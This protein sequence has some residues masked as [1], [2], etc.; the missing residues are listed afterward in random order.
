MDNQTFSFETDVL[1]IGGGFSGSWAAM[2]ARSHAEN[3]LIVDKGPRDWGGLGSMSGGDMIVKGAE[4]EALD[5]VD[6][7]VYYYDGLCE[8][9]I[10]FDILNA[11]YERFQDLERMGHVFA[12][13]KDGA[14]FNIPQRGLELMRFYTY[15]PYGEG[16]KHTTQ[17][18]NQRLH[19]LGVRRLGR[20]EIV[21]LLKHGNVISGAVGFHAQSGNPIYIKAKAVILA[22]HIGGW[23]GSYLLNTCAGE[24]AAL[25][26]D[27]G[28]TLRNMEYI[29]NWNVPKQFAWEGQ[30]GLLPYGACFRNANGEDFMQQYSPKF[31]AKA[32][33][34][35]NIRGMA[36]EILQ[37]RGP[38][39]FDTS[40]LS[41]EGV[42]AMTPQRGWMKLNDDKLKKLGIDFFK[43][44]TEWISQVLTSFGG[45]YA[46][47][48][49][50]T[51]ITGLYVAGRAR[52]ITPGVYMGGWDTCL[53]FT[54]GFI[55]GN[56]A[57][58]YSLENDLAE[59][60]TDEAQDA[61]S[62]Y[63]A[64]LGQPG[65]NPKDV[66][67]EMQRLMAPIDVSI[68]KTGKGLIRSLEKLLLFKKNILPKMT[69]SDPHYLVKFMEAE[70]MVLLTEMYLQ[71][72]L[73][74]KESRAGHYRADFPNRNEK[75]AWVA[76]KKT[77][78]GMQL[79]DMSVPID[80]Y[81][82]QPQCYYMDNFSFPTELNE[83]ILTHSA[84]S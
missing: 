36:Y 74:R 41:E 7:L 84:I 79:F 23:K 44:K 82:I 52:S 45:V 68:L 22:S 16:G 67:R 57:G 3:V 58:K 37:G 55:A 15:H 61:V 33:P 62:Y 21:K 8:Q 39:Y 83:V 17:I 42:K 2:T 1:I 27:V 40:T 38:I 72:S 30:T 10:L 49:G 25:A 13:D 76:L 20:V 59:Y 54:T 31:G 78:E 53:T 77:K 80:A 5:L 51:N 9:D 63:T 11:S 60:N 46:D 48:N 81:P 12:R 18:L 47:K 34:H 71:S 64:K 75:L 56:S 28:A 26:Y 19:E 14:L 43:Q 35:Y 24:G 6:E 73:M 29:E 4:F 32:D 65:L 69:A 50:M 70:S 66:V